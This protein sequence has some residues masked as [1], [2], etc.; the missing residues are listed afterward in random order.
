M[1]RRTSIR[2]PGLSKSVS[3]HAVR[4]RS[5]RTTILRA[6]KQAERLREIDE[7]RA[8]AIEGMHIF[9]ICPLKLV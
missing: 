4:G 6:G 5:R 9:L 8:A 7:Q 1:S 2:Y 3:L